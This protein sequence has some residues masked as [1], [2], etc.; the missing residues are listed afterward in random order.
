MNVL[1]LLIFL[2]SFFQSFQTN[3]PKIWINIILNG[4]VCS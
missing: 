1:D 4:H 3:T 2:E